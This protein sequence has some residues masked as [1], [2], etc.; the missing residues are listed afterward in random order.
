MT[1]EKKRGREGEGE[2]YLTDYICSC[3]STKCESI[4]S[5]FSCCDLVESKLRLAINDVRVDV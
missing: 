5:C 3:S 2:T 4:L 1:K